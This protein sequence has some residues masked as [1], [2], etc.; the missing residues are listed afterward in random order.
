MNRTVL[1]TCRQCAG[2][3]DSRATDKARATYLQ[4]EYCLG[5]RHVNIDR[6]PDGGVPD[7]ETEWL[8]PMLAPFPQ[9]D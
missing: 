4:C 6:T 8:G 2:T 5:Q 1:V 7:G 3:G 9:P